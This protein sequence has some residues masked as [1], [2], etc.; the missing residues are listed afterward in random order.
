MANSLRIKRRVTGLGGAPASLKTGELAWNMVDDTV[1]GG[2]G[3]DGGGNAT[4]VIA[5]AGA[6]AFVDKA[7]NQS[8]AGTKTFSVS[9]VLPTPSTGDDSTK[10][11]TT[12]FVKAQGYRTQNETITLSGDLSG[13]GATSIVATLANSGVSAGTYAKVTVDA[14][15][16]VTVGASLAAG[17]IPTI[18]HSKISD[19]DAGVRTNRLDQMAAPTGNVDFNSKRITG[20][21]DPVDQTD[22]VNKRYADALKSNFDFKDSARAAT[23]GN[24]TLSGAQT[25]DGV[26]VVAGNR[27]LVKNQS[28]ASQNGIYV[29]ATGAWSRATDFDEDTE[30]TSGALAFVEEGTV[31]G[32]QQWILTTTGSITVGS[33]AL[34]FTQFGG[35]LTYGAGNGLSLAGS[36]FSVKTVSA[37]RIAVGA[38][39]VDLA[40]GVISSP[41][42][43]KSLTVDTYGRVT[44]G[45]NPTTL[46]GFGITDAQPLHA[47]LT[48]LAGL[49]ASANTLGYFNGT[50][51]MAI[52]A[53]TA[54]G[55]TLIGAADDAAARTA[56]A[57]G[58][59]ATQS[60]AS[61][62]ITGGSID[63]V[64]MDGGIF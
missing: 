13:S 51:T 49:S 27:V 17:D 60:A 10:A 62:A 28:T 39:G 15:G 8:I 20:L 5:L 7:S 25:I 18:D 43:Y 38:G 57:L 36:T 59:M 14:K 64:T 56:L 3:D 32:G 53:F 42:T 26:A 63:N 22:A 35:G 12:A 61:V 30:V 50:S 6:G 47:K 9:P 37:G 55:R 2:K 29:A 45:T 23:T 4:S 44:G 48:A 1:Y 40:S 24:I 31:N 21:A 34:V 46:A 41:G 52:T 16:R 33:T 19:F 11:A 54:F 58:S